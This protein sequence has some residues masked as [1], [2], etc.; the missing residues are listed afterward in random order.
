MYLK[1]KDVMFQV[2]FDCVDFFNSFGTS[3]TKKGAEDLAK[4]CEKEY[5]LKPE[6]RKI[7]I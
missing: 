7:K 1:R 5:G 4:D 6:I 2:G 3:Y